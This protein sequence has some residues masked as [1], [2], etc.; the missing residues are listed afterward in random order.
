[1]KTN[2]S[3]ES[4]FIFLGFTPGFGDSGQRVPPTSHR[5]LQPQAVG[6]SAG[7]TFGLI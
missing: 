2:V 5:T 1:M 3:S 4:K 6:K 7:L